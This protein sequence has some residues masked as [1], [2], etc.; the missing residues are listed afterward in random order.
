M[1]API[2]IFAAAR[3]ALALTPVP[4]AR[5]DQ[6]PPS[7]SVTGS[8]STSAVPDT[9]RVSAGVVSE[10]PGAADAVR[11]N[12]AAMQQVFAALEKA[13]IPKKDIQ[14]RNFSLSPLYAPHPRR[15]DVPEIIGYRAENLVEVSVTGVDKVGAVLD[16][17]VAAGA[18]QIGGISFSVGEPDPLLDEARRKA[19]ADARRKAELLATAAGAKLGRVLQIEEQGGGRPPGPW[20]MAMA[21]AEA[22]PVPVA[23]GQLELA[24]TVGVTWALEP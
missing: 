13:G 3:A 22:A 5:A 17:L 12:T 24:V 7:I 2:R 14:T 1:K 6:A 8:G 4:A 20:P 11:A 15:T 19:V 18:N 16:R 23:P 21:R 9:G 10:A